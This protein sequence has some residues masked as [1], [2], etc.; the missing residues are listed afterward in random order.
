MQLMRRTGLGSVRHFSQILLQY[1]EC[2]NKEND[3]EMRKMGAVCVK[4]FSILCPILCK[5]LNCIDIG[6]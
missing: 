2:W 6:K 4:R 3:D 5:H 1:E